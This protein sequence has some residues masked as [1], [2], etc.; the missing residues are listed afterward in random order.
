ME[1]STQRKGEENMGN[2]DEHD[3]GKVG[4]P[5]ALATEDEHDGGRVGVPKAL[6]QEE[7][8]DGE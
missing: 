6:V 4:V 1:I 2:T 3:G 8:T 5:K 7:P